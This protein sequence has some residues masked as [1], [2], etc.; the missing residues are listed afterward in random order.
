MSAGDQHT[1]GILMESAQLRCWG[2]NAD[3]QSTVPIEYSRW[4]VNSQPAVTSLSHCDCCMPQAIGAGGQHTCGIV[5]S[6]AAVICWG[7]NIDGQTT[8]PSS[9][10][11]GAKVSLSNAAYQIPSPW[12]SC[13]HTFVI[14][15]L[16][17]VGGRTRKLSYLRDQSQFQSFGL[18]GQ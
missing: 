8:V 15:D 13:Y 7:S 6:S 12:P 10:S 5:Q 16:V 14:H 18:L 17:M 3:F 4:Q 1:C 11:T 2:E 9:L